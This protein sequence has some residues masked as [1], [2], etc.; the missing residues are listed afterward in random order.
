MKIALIVLGVLA[1]LVIVGALV[2]YGF[3]RSTDEYNNSR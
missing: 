1:V 3:L 2:F